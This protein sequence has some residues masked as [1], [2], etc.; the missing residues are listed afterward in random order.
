MLAN[1]TSAYGPNVHISELKASDFKCFSDL[2]LSIEHQPKLVVVCGENGAGKSSV[3][4]AVSSWRLRQHFGVADPAYFTKGGDTN[5]GAGAGSLSI[6][7]HEGPPA[8]PRASVYVRTA[9]RV[10]VDFSG[11]GV[12]M[13]QRPRELAGPAR[14]ADLDDRVAENYQRLVA[15]SISALWD[16][17]Q[18]A[19]AIGDIVDEL[20]G[21]VANPLGRL[22]PGLTFEGPDRPLEQASTFR[23]SKG[24]SQRYAYKHLSG[25]EKAVFDLLLDASMKAIE[26]QAAIWCIDEPELH[27]NPRIHGELL[28]ELLGLLHADAQLWITTH[29]AGMLAEARRQYT[30][31]PG[32][33]A[34]LDLTGVDTDQPLAL[35]PVRPDRRFWRNQL[36][37]ALGDLAELVA[38]ARVVLCEGG[39]DARDRPRARWD[40]RVLEQV[41]GAAYPDTSFVS[42][43]SADDVVGDRM[44]VGATIEALVDG[45][46][47]LRVI[48][49][50][51]RSG[52]E[53][54][55]LLEAGCRVL[56]RR[57][58]EAYLL[59]EDVLEALCERAEQPEKLGQLQ[60]ALADSLQASVERGNPS[61][62]FKS[63]SSQFVNAA[64]KILA[65][66]AAGNS[67]ATYLRDSLAPLLRP[68]MR[69]YE[70][71]REDIFGADC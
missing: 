63:A 5:S 33:V 31:D 36:A 17:T 2:K 40:A 49:R 41:F 30:E 11:S 51:S 52:R 47:T 28:K 4:D 38:P 15:A 71:L 54:E 67:T 12:Q 50:D 19:R 37:I 61:D 18:R 64:R 42:V 3:L 14:S 9:Q 25:G 69:S 22:L 20:V 29:S 8:D 68:G 44:D 56:R 23:F 60:Q 45:T 35:E 13:L 46:E 24:V 26:F 57:H 10:T 65:A 16:Q 55:D 70:E 32:R 39:P 21:T 27:V 48:D 66:N 34:F 43:G 58:L 62:D 53:V 1:R 7:F 59:D 6:T